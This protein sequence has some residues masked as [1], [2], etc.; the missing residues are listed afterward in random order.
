MRFLILPGEDGNPLRQLIKSGFLGDLRPL[1]KHLAEL[2]ILAVKRHFAVREAIAVTDGNPSDLLKKTQSYKTAPHLTFAPSIAAIPRASSTLAVAA[3]ADVDSLFW[4]DSMPQ[5]SRLGLVAPCFFL[6]ADGSPV[7]AFLHEY[8]LADLPDFCRSLRDVY[9]HL[10]RGRKRPAEY[11]VSCYYRRLRSV[12]DLLTVTKEMLDGTAFAPSCRSTRGVYYDVAAPTGSYVAVP[13]V[14]FGVGAQ[15]ETG[16]VVGPYAVIGDDSVISEGA[17]VENAWTGDGVYLSRDC[18]VRDSAIGEDASLRL[19]AAVIGGS[20]LGSSGVLGEGSL[21]AY[22]A[23]LPSF[24]VVGGDCTVNRGD[25]DGADVFAM[26]YRE[27]VPATPELVTLLGGAAG[28]YCPREL[29][30]LDD[31]T[32]RSAALKAAFVSGALCAGAFV[33]D[34]G[35]AVRGQL[36][37]FALRLRQRLYAFISDGSAPPIQ[38]FDADGR[39]LGKRET[40]VL[41]SSPKKSRP[42]SAATCADVR[43]DL[44]EQY[45]ADLFKW[46]KS[47]VYGHAFRVVCDA[48]LLAPAVKLLNGFSEKGADREETVFVINRDGTRLTAKFGGRTYRHATL[49]ASAALYELRHKKRL[50][51]PWNAPSFL[52]EFAATQGESNTAPCTGFPSHDCLWTADACYLL[53]KLLETEDTTGKTVAELADDVPQFY[54]SE[55]ALDVDVE[56]GRLASAAGTRG[57]DFTASDGVLEFRSAA[58]KARLFPYSDGLRLHVISEAVNAEAAAEL[59]AEIQEIIAAATLDNPF[60]A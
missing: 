19:G 53:V 36:P 24:S 25:G 37:Q 49:L 18:V 42:D 38:F 31:G 54:L 3:L 48:P 10:Q 57:A 21:A 16:A 26:L 33:T 52:A 20:A 6:S 43:S 15:I 40:A 17:R 46:M 13:P 27:D 5:L 51:L 32:A 30:V 7:V 2:Q 28:A 58:G 34:A 35:S 11:P 23:L 56:V 50:T 8:D 39:P 1:S 44:Q 12:G 59:I 4:F 41:C 60:K 29:C 55:N 45:L 9:R 14:Y 47:L 22:S